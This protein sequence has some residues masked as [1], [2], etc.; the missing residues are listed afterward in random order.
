M[1][2][3]KFCNNPSPPVCAD[4]C[5][6]NGYYVSPDGTACIPCP[7]C[8]AGQELNK[9]C[10]NGLNGDAVCIPCLEGFFSLSTSQ[11]C[12]QCTTCTN[13]VEQE[14]CQLTQNRVCG[15]CLP[16]F[17][18]GSDRF[19]TDFNAC[20]NR[21]SDL[22][23]DTPQ[24]GDWWSTQDRESIEVEQPTEIADVRR[25]P[26]E[27]SLDGID[28]CEPK[29]PLC[30]DPCHD[31]NFFL[32]YDGLCKACLSCQP[33]E[34]LN[35]VCGRGK[36]GD[37]YCRRCPEGTFS[38]DGLQRCSPCRICVNTLATECTASRNTACGECLPGYYQDADG[39]FP[40]QGACPNKCP[41]C[42][43]TV[44]QCQEWCES[45]TNPDKVTVGQDDVTLA[46]VAVDIHQSGADDGIN[47]EAKLPP[48]SHGSYM[49]IFTVLASLLAVVI[50]V[51]FTVLFV[52][53]YM[54]NRSNGSNASTTPILPS[55]RPSPSS[56]PPRTPPTVY[57]P[58]T[59][60]YSPEGYGR[61]FWNFIRTASPRLTSSR[62]V[63]GGS[64]D[65]ENES[66]AVSTPTMN[67]NRR[68]VERDLLRHTLERQVVV[69]HD[70]SP[71]L[72]PPYPLKHP[73]SV[74][75]ERMVNSAGSMNPAGPF[76]GK[77]TFPTQSVAAKE[78]DRN[79]VPIER[80][81]CSEE[82]SWSRS[83]PSGK[84]V[85]ERASGTVHPHVD[86]TDEAPRTRVRRRSIIS[87]NSL[88]EQ[89]LPLLNN[90][91]RSSLSDLV[92]GNNRQKSRNGRN[93]NTAPVHEAVA[94]LFPTDSSSDNGPTADNPVDTNNTKSAN[95]NQPSQ[96]PEPNASSHKTPTAAAGNKPN[97]CKCT[98][99][100]SPKEIPVENST[101]E[102]PAA[103]P[104]DQGS[105]GNK[106]PGD[107]NVTINITMTTKDVET[108]H[109]GDV[110]DK[111]NLHDGAHQGI[112][113][114]EPNNNNDDNNGEAQKLLN[115]NMSACET[116]TLHLDSSDHDD[117]DNAERD[118]LLDPKSS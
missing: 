115:V 19:S 52:F 22:P 87:N 25:L 24:C 80:L 43:N 23:R 105:I 111:R 39:Y 66:S 102:K 88:D 116:D 77:E 21:C 92:L 37:A 74:K 32:D 31:G 108:V 65:V 15:D 117:D 2:A 13:T 16:G 38:E 69:D 42:P 81:G 73:E 11:R 114:S 53:R 35:K 100:V 36:N 12:T 29:T 95:P 51:L 101:H 61:E 64:T 79:P 46:D 93:G 83:T 84:V 54:W 78:S 56:S 58:T 8:S 110:H 96:S 14:T 30:I 3:S 70:G 40:D 60:Q 47:D 9:D 44:P 94:A 34:E 118:K 104:D 1:G 41:E 57:G 72:I 99:A 113:A 89:L 27:V 109:I 49:L 18:R 68:M 20:P 97:G 63:S 82:S 91:R 6:G 107:T 26:E 50:I 75:G 98:L 67:L 33:G 45:R 10:G 7:Q 90:N 4:D 62:P 17:F 28:P 106:S 112:K 5:D 103:I 85:T 55:P 86:D 76:H 71:R 59:F 48:A